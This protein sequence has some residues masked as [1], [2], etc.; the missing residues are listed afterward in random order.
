MK[1]AIITVRG[2]VQGVGFR[3]FVMNSAKKNNI[4]GYVMNLSNGNVLIEAEGD[5]CNLETFIDVIN[6]GPISADV[7]DIIIE[8]SNIEN[9]SEFSIKY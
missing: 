7:S 1:H 4:N 2:Y 6:S 8:Y 5:I 9:Y 3:Y